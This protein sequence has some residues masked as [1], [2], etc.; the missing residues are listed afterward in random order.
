MQFLPLA[1]GLSEGVQTIV[2]DTGK[3]S[4]TILPTRGMGIWQAKI[5]GDEKVSTIGWKSPVRGP[6][7]P[8]FV[9]VGEPSG[10]GWL[11]GFDELLVRC[12][13]QSNGAPEFDPKTGKLLWPV[14]GLIANRPAHEVSL[15]INRETQEISVTGVVEET[16]FHFVKLR[17]TSTITAK[18]RESTIHV[19]DE[20]ENFSGSP[21]EIQMLYH[22]NFGVPL[23]DAGSQLVAP[24][25]TL[26][27]RNAH[28]ATGIGQ[29]NSYAAPQPGTEEQV[30]FFELFAA[31]NGQT[32]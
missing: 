2:V 21:A 30:Y 26:V 4:F 28:A 3:I 12:G 23:L 20:I 22:V 18:L 15:T 6:V 5:N 32:H 10:L 8:K 17:M 7:H 1:A 16:R 9:N 19:Q 29:W 11:D 27:P 25:Q 14:H 31:A 24:V 13:L